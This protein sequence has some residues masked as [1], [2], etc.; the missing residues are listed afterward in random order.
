DVLLERIEGGTHIAGARVLVR[1]RC[2]QRVE[3]RLRA[4]QRDAGAQP[5]DHVEIVVV[6]IA[7]VEPRSQIQRHPRRTPG[8]IGSV[9]AAGMTPTTVNG[10]PLMTS[11]WP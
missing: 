1:E 2:A 6:G 9:Y 11:A 8:A 4:S 5:A 3:L 7:G 10:V